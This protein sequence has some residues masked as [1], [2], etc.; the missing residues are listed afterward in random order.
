MGEREGEGKVKGGEGK[1][2]GGE[3]KGGE[4]RG[5]RR[6]REWEGR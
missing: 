3:V 6:S 5:R 1:V 2:K 4:G